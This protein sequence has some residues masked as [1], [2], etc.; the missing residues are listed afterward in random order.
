MRENVGTFQG[1]AET[2]ATGVS[3]TSP[4]Y[5]KSIFVLFEN[6]LLR[7]A[8]LRLVFA[9]LYPLFS[10]IPVFPQQLALSF[11]QHHKTCS[12]YPAEDLR[13]AASANPVLSSTPF[14]VLQ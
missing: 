10:G 12:C 3:L 7:F 9:C 1:K 2:G 6:I 11:P 14:V 13:A 8:D 5:V 4:I